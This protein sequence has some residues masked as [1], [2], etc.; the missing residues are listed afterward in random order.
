MEPRP[1]SLE[2]EV[3][4]A[5]RVAAERHP[6]VLSTFSAQAVDEVPDDAMPGVEEYLA[7]FLDLAEV[8]SDA[9]LRLAAEVDRLNAGQGD[10]SR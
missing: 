5:L 7:A 4:Q 10:A 1:T 2:E 9:V 6:K 3:R 8:V